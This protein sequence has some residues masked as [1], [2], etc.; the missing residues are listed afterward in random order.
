LIEFFGKPEHDKAESHPDKEWILDYA[1]RCFS[2]KLALFKG[3][4]RNTQSEA[5]SHARFG[6]VHD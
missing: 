5:P 4:R 3:Y 1:G 2:N 6:S